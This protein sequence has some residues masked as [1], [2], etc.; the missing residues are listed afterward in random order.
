M[1]FIIH[2]NLLIKPLFN[3]F[4]TVKQVQELTL[5]VCDYYSTDGSTIAHL[6]L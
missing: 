4:V 1:S 3:R 5:P 6:K 2:A